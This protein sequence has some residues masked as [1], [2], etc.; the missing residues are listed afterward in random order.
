M[1]AADAQTLP[2]RCEQD[3]V[4]SR[5]K[6]RALAQALKFSLV[7]QTNMITAVSLGLP[8]SRRLVHEFEIDPIPPP[9]PG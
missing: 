5:Q 2:L 7:D 1:P 6:A 8:G 3:I 9:A 4:A